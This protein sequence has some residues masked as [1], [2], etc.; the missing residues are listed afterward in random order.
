M[1]EEDGEGEKAGIYLGG[2]GEATRKKK[3]DGE[4]EKRPK[5]RK[6]DTVEALYFSTQNR[7]LFPLNISCSRYKAMHYL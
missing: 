3:K 7:F 4:G 2:G 6:D 5:R 1:E